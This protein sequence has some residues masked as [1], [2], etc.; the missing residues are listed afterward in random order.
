MTFAK[1]FDSSTNCP[2]RSPSLTARLHKNNN[3]VVPAQLPSMAANF[4]VERGGSGLSF[5]VS[6]KK[7]LWTDY[8]NMYWTL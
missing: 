7:P 2:V 8:M 1:D 6:F 4:A 5:W 3:R